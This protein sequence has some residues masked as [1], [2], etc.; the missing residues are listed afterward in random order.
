MS[1]IL[2]NL[3]ETIESLQDEIKSKDKLLEAY[4]KQFDR[5]LSDNNGLRASI[6]I[7]NQ[8]LVKIKKLADDSDPSYEE[9]QIKKI[10][11]EKSEAI[12]KL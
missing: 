3:K 11:K 7:L 12:L 10:L 2:D 4:Q 1:G 9:K 6:G 8:A 5:E